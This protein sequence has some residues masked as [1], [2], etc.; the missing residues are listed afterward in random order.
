MGR[1]KK[2]SGNVGRSLVRAKHKKQEKTIN[3]YKKTKIEITS[4]KQRE[5]KKN[6]KS[7]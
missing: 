3:K 7:Q 4:T 6:S 1:T 5:G 2:Q